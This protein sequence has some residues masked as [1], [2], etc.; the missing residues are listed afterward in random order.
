MD[1][2]TTDPRLDPARN[3]MPFDGK[4]MIYGGFQPIV[5]GPAN[6]APGYADG[7]LTPVSPDKRQAYVDM[8][9]TAAAVFREYG[10]LR[11]VECWSDD[12]PDGTLTDFR[13]AVQATDG[14]AVVFSFLEWPDKATRDEGWKK[15][16]EDP[17]MQMDPATMPFD[18]KRMFWGGFTPVVQL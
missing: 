12:V 17:R 4:R 2:S 1:P 3:P 16:M 8:A 11:S 7:F 10:A 13:R 5:D 9:E 15:V 18:G 14:E 6:G